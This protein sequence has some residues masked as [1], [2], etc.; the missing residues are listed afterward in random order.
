MTRKL[1]LFLG[2]TLLGGAVMVFAEETITITTY[3]PSP[4]GSYRELTAHQMK[5]G[6]NY[7]N[8]PVVAV[9]DSLIVQG[10]IGIGT[11]TPNSTLDV[12]GD[13]ITNAGITLG[14]ERRTTWPVS[15]CRWVEGCNRDVYCRISC[16]AGEVIAGGGCN[17][18]STQP[19]GGYLSA[20][21]PE[22]WA[23]P[24]NWFCRAI[25]PGSVIQFGMAYCCKR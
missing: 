8:A 5:I 4:Y 2:L 3:Y 18:I 11:A 21:F 1:T 24:P 23:N 7:A 16:A 17:A 13:I 6:S 22:Y 9:N 25:G 10:R 14:G 15:S 20:S 19:G 12:A